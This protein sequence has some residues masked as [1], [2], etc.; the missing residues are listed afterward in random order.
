MFLKQSKIIIFE[1]FWQ[2]HFINEKKKVISSVLK[3]TLK[4]EYLFWKF[5]SIH[6]LDKKQYL[7]ENA[8]NLYKNE[9]IVRNCY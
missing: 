4:I 3:L 6:I 5:V 2:R 9:F 7:R 8:E 1:L